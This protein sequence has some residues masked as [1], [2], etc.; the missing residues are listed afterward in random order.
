[1]FHRNFTAELHCSKAPYV[2]RVGVT[3]ALP[4]SLL[5]AEE[6]GWL[7]I[8]RRYKSHHVQPIRFKFEYQG[9]TED[10]VH[11]MIAS[12]TRFRGLADG[13]LGF[14]INGYVGFYGI[15]TTHEVLNHVSPL[16]WAL[17]KQATVS[18]WKVE[19]LGA[20]DGTV[21]GAERL[22]IHLRDSTGRRIAVNRASINGD[23]YLNV[24]SGEVLTFQ[25]R[26]VSLI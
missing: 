8:D 5:S 18:Y 14:S 7:V 1:M 26:N 12:S 25:L 20:W 22:D 3:A 11:Y 19:V 15:T 21:E 24:E 13:T 9:H 10:R 23:E 2:G 6:D 4:G 17:A 16:Y